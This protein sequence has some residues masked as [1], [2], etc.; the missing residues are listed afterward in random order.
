MVPLICDNP[1]HSFAVIANVFYPMNDTENIGIHPK[2]KSNKISQERSGKLL[3]S[4]K[5]ILNQAIACQGTTIINF[6]Y[7]Q[8]RNGNF[9]PLLRAIQ[10]MVVQP[11]YQPN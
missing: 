3:K 10:P 11:M 8:N 2:S 6:S 7:G 1:Y 5:D 9:S 4:I